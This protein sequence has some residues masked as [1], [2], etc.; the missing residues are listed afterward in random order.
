MLV[1]YQVHS[2]QP[3]SRPSTADSLLST[4]PHIS[5]GSISSD[6]QRTADLERT[7]QSLQSQ[8]GFEPLL[9]LF[10]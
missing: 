9:F 8:V 1:C 6:L 5:P 3:G 4:A 2:A 7:C 10:L